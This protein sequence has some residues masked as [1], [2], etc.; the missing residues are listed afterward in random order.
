MR[1]IRAEMDVPPGKP[2][3]VLRENWRETDQQRYAATEA[4]I[5]ALARPESV[6]WVAPDNSA[7][8]SATALVGSMRLLIPLAG[9]IDPDAERERLQRELQKA[10]SALDASHKKLANEQFVSRAPEAIFAKERQRLE[11]LMVARGQL[12]RQLEKISALQ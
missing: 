10:D 3:P 9:L 7:P 8:D 12:A 6:G 1:R 4:W 5:L 2:V 11:E